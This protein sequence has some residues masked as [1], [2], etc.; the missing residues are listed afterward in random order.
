MRTYTVHTKEEFEKERNNL[1]VAGYKTKQ[2]VGG[3]SAQLIKK[4]KVSAGFCVLWFIL[5]I[6]PLFIYLI[7]CAA[8]KPQDDVLIKLE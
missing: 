1:I 7:Y 6:F 4:K 2:E 3:E 5:G 8:R